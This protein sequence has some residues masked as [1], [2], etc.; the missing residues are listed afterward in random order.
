MS[1]VAGVP[2]CYWNYWKSME[3]P[4]GKNIRSAWV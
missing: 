3:I 1:M 2:M 4:N